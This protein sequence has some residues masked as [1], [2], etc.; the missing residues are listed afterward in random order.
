MSITG[1]DATTVTALRAQLTAAVD[2]LAPELLELS[3]AIG[4]DPELA[5]DEHR[6]ATRVAAV[7]GRHG[8][9]VEVGAFGLPTAVAATYGD[10]EVTVAVVGEY[11][12]L[13]EVGHGCGHN[14]IAAAGVGAAVALAAVADRLGI[15]VRFLGTPAEELGGGKIVMLEAGAWNDATFSLMVHGGMAE[16]YSAVGLT[17]Q[18]FE[19]VV[20]RFTGVA[21]HAAAAPHDGINAADAVTLA[22]VAIGLARQQLRAG[23]VVSSFVEEAGRATNIIPALGVLQVEMRAVDRAEWDRARAKVRDC[24]EAAALATGCTL[25]IE[26]PEPPY[27]V[28]AQHEPLARLWDD[29]LVARGYDVLSHHEMAAGS[30]DMANVSR[31]LPSIHP[32]IALRGSDAVPHTAGYAAAASSPAGDGAVVDGAIA[33]ALTAARAAADPALRAELLAAQAVRAPYPAVSPVAE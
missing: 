11:D 31:Y 30:T 25:E 9:E 33:L 4:A 15:R 29:E 10:G 13:P 24:L 22:Q 20:A 23:T 14:L 3:H 6:A 17:T 12:A 18:A 5:F 26:L 28:L 21:A 16:Q 19:R 8:F 1:L 2:G 32:M 7:L 27:D